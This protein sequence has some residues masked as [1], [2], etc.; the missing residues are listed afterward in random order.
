MDRETI[1]VIKNEVNLAYSINFMLLENISKILPY[2]NQT[3]FT[4]EFFK[5]VKSNDEKYID[6]L[7]EVYSDFRNQIFAEIRETFKK[8]NL[9]DEFKTKSAEFLNCFNS[10]F[11]KDVKYS[12]IFSERDVADWFMFNRMA[13]MTMSKMKTAKNYDEIKLK[14]AFTEFLVFY[15]NYKNWLAEMEVFEKLDKDITEIGS[16]SVFFEK[17]T[18]PN[19]INVDITDFYNFASEAQKIIDEQKQKIENFIKNKENLSVQESEDALFLAQALA[20]IEQSLIQTSNRFNYAN[21]NALELG[22]KFSK[23]GARLAKGKNTTNFKVEKIYIHK[24]ELISMFDDMKYFSEFE[25]QLALLG[26][27]IFEEATI[28]VEKPKEKVNNQKE[29]L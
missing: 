29:Q 27:L 8:D 3:I 9:T 10:A 6:M 13:S 17:P 22:G 11:K 28:T 18:N 1:D 19:I 24:N 20:R 5:R 21:T 15:D 26:S 7:F 14:N 2:G 12:A 16:K 4:S 25:N 23:L